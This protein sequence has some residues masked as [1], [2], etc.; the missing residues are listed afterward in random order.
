MRVSNWNW[1]ETDKMVVTTTRK[2]AL[3]AANV[4]ADRV[5]RDCPVGTISRPMYEKGSYAGQEW[6]KRDAGELKKSVR[7]VER[8][9]EKYGYVLAQFKT[10]G[11]Y[12]DV[13]VYVGHYLAWYAQIVEY[14]TPFMRPALA[15]TRSKVKDIL[16]NG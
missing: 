15:A 11:N 10:I 16:E 13:R 7:V 8:D 1:K 14:Y 9:E 2:R 6:T 4:I 5:R 12:G 3:K